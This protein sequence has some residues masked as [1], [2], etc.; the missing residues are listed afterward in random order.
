MGC[1]F[2]SANHVRL[3]IILMHDMNLFSFWVKVSGF[4]QIGKTGIKIR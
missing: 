1:Y 4:Y 2:E 3:I